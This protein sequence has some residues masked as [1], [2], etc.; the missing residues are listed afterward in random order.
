[1]K[2]IMSFVMVTVIL[3]STFWL[4]VGKTAAAGIITYTGGTYVWGKG[5]SFSFDASGYKNKDLKNA[6]ILVGSNLHD[7]HCRL[8]KEKTK[9]NCV[10]AGGLTQYAGEAGVIYLAGQVFYVTIPDRIL[11]FSN[12]DKTISCPE[13]T[14]TGAEVTFL[15]GGGGR[16]TTFISGSTREEVSNSAKSHVDGSDLVE[17]LDVGSLYCAEESPR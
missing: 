11:Y 15:T 1:M 6:S 3:I 12:G 8:N 4:S 5:I 17:V 14:T 16:Y 13:G 10:A 9:I 7:L 2:K